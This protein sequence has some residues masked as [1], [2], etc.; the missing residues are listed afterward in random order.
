MRRFSPRTDYD[1]L[2]D[3]YQLPLDGSVYGNLEM[4]VMIQ[5]G[6][7]LTQAFSKCVGK[8]VVVNL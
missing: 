6:T 1:F 7:Y 3:V 4:H 2:R 5:I 8:T